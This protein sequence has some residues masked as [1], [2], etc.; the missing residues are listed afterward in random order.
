MKTTR[1]TEKI[2]R[3]KAKMGRLEALEAGITVTLVGKPRCDFA[4]DFIKPLSLR[5]HGQRILDLFHGYL[6]PQFRPDHPPA[7][8]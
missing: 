2:E 5:T 7:R 1:L 6:G 8:I 3:L 4:G